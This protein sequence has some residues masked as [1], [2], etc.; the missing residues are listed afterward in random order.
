MKLPVLFYTLFFSCMSLAHDFKYM[1]VN[2]DPNCILA[3]NMESE[4]NLNNCSNHPEQKIIKD[5]S[6]KDLVGYHY[7]ENGVP[8]SMYYTYLGKINNNFVVH[9]GAIGGKFSRLDFINYFKIQ[10][11]KLILVKRGPSG[12]RSFGGIS[13]TKIVK[14]NIIYDL[15]NTALLFMV[16]FTHLKTRNNP[17]IENLT[18]CAVCEFA[19]VHYYNNKITSVTLNNEVDTNNQCLNQLHAE[20]KKQNKL[21]LTLKQAEDFA[22][23][24]LN[25]CA[26]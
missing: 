26:K 2:I 19:K 5:I 9:A 16:N 11:N 10:D 17:I 6:N 15:S 8:G 7:K 22:A 21:E 13:N 12:D 14:N 24:F 1:G 23:T 20:Y 18:D 4:I 25:K 3:S